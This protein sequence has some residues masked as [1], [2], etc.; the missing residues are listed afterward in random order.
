MHLILALN[1]TILPLFFICSLFPRD[2]LLKN[3]QWLSKSLPSF[4]WDWPFTMQLGT[5]AFLL[6]SFPLSAPGST[7]LNVAV[8][9][10]LCRKFLLWLTHS[11]PSGLT[12]SNYPT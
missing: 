3:L 7:Y 8:Y 6:H 2:S 10:V 11:L 9:N 12:L 4:V 5:L 1:L